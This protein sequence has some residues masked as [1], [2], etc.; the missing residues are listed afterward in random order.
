MNVTGQLRES[1]AQTNATI[2]LPE[3]DDPRVI[4]A[5][6]RL[7]NQQIV[8]PILLGN[9]QQIF[10]AAAHAKL[11]PPTKINIID[12][13]TSD[14]REHFAERFYEKRKSKG[15]TLE[16][17]AE[18]VADPLVF[19]ALMVDG[20]GADGCVAGAAN[21]TRNVLRAALQVI[22]V[23]ESNSIVSSCFL[24]VLP[25]GRPLTYGDCGMVP[26]PTAEQLASIAIAT[27]HT[28][29]Q[30]TGED[31]VVA[32]LSFSTKGSAEHDSVDKVR[33]A[34]ELVRQAQPDLLID[35]ELQFDAAYVPAV[36]ER[37]APDSAVAGRA[38][39]FIFPNLDAGNIA[40]KI[41]E[42]LGG[43]QALGPI[44]QGLA[45]PMHDLSRG[46]GT[47]DIVTMSAIA[48]VQAG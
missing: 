34:L 41:T 47:D 25:D 24:M 23:R 16:E 27:A 12:P 7:R 18:R 42:R 43:A 21:A 33:T 17:A 14:Q 37:K 2:V 20:G 4:Q 40:Y 44:I 13:A 28:H 22:G 45:K 30:L 3:G 10:D 36:G 26:N 15:I 9:S 38:N 32:M 35:G 39:V 5:A 11:E 46:C 29:T 48:A 19:G 6:I 31:P 8:Q 1:A